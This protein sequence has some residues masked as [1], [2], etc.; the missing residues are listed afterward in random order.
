MKTKYPKL[1]EELK[2]LA[3]EIRTKKSQRKLVPNGQV[4]GLYSDQEEFRHKHIAYCM[5]HGTLYEHIEQPKENNKPCLESI[6]HY[7]EVYRETVCDS[8]QQPE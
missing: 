5:L 4:K 2:V 1:K 8:G 3:R 6:E 7:L